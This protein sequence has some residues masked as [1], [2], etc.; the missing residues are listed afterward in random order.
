MSSL[1]VAGWDARMGGQETRAGYE[2]TQLMVRRR[3]PKD[4]SD[5]TPSAVLSKRPPSSSRSIDRS[6][7]V[8]QGPLGEK[9]FAPPSFPGK[10]QTTRDDAQ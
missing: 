9:M 1:L 8:S 2:L 4:D 10:G 6:K 7:R 5:L 3:H